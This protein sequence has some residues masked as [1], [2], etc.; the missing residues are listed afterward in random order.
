VRDHRF[1]ILLQV[2][3]AKHPVLPEVPLAIDLAATDDQRQIMKMLFARQ[4]W[5]R[6]FAALP[7]VPEAR[8]AALR[9]AFDR[10][11]SDQLLREEAQRAK[12][13]ITPVG[14]ETIQKEIFDIYLTSPAIVAAALQATR[15]Q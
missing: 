6:P 15:P 12:L 11:M 3:T 5:G 7:G 14:G 10:A 13:E 8:V 1:K 4:L 9:D 2:S